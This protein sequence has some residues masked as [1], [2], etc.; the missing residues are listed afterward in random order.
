VK[1]IIVFN[2]LVLLL[3]LANVHIEHD[4]GIQQ[5]SE[6][7]ILISGLVATWAIFK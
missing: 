1:I 3:S 2:V 4:F 7:Y 5:M 6:A